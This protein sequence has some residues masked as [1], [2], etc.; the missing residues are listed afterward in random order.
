MR[1][2][3]SKNTFIDDQTPYDVSD[4]KAVDAFWADAIPHKGVEELRRLRGQRGPQKAPVKEAISI[5]L[6]T[7]VLTAFRRSGDGWQTRVNVALGD[8]L[9]E[10]SPEE[11]HLPKELAE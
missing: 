11:I 8:W 1:K 2:T 4:A 5:R 10:H 9:K 7:E 6:D 3:H